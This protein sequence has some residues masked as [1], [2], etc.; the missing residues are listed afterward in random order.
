MGSKKSSVSGGD[1]RLRKTNGHYVHN[2][3][4]RCDVCDLPCK[5]DR[6]V[7]IHK[8][9]MHK[10]GY[11]MA[12]K[13]ETQQVERAVVVCQGVPVENVYKFIYLGGG[14]RFPTGL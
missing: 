3:T 11:Y 14:C 4:Y 10:K 7:Q 8:R 13:W 1:C 5:S 2:R 9:V 12:K 6:G